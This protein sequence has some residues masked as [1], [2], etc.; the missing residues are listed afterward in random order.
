MNSIQRVLVFSIMTALVM[1]IPLMSGAE[2]KVVITMT[3]SSVGQEGDL[4]REGAELYMKEHPNVDIQIFDVPD[5]TTARFIL[6]LKKLTAQDPEIDIYQIDVIWP[7]EMAEFFV[8]LYQHGADQLTGEHFPELIQNNTVDGRLVAMPW[9]T[10]AGLL[11]YRTDL[12]EKYGYSA[13]PETWDELEEMA[14][15]IQD[16][17]VARRARKFLGLCLAGQY[18]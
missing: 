2:D 3:G 7:G 5:S 8:D 1:G 17:E 12:L 10:D 11:Y 14:K 9:F 15:T 18:L 6:Y 4:I 13:P 16:G